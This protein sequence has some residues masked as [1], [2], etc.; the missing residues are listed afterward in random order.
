MS[1]LHWPASEGHGAQ[2]AVWKSAKLLYTDRLQTAHVARAAACERGYPYILEE[3]QKQGP[4]K[5]AALGLH[6][7]RAFLRGP[8]GE[9]ENR[10]AVLVLH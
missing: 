8:Y 5:G 6:K 7:K 10:S 2:Y 3:M 9:A 1:L 4:E